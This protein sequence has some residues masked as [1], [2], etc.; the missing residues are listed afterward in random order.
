MS[1]ITSIDLAEA[2]TLLQ[3]RAYFHQYYFELLSALSFRGCFLY[4]PFNGDALGRALVEHRPHVRCPG[5]DAQE[6]EERCSPDVLKL[7]SGAKPNIFL[8][9]PW[10][11]VSLELVTYASPWNASHFTN[12]SHIFDYNKDVSGSATWCEKLKEFNNSIYPLD[13]RARLHALGSAQIA[14]YST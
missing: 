3:A 10:T 5:W 7:T 8:Q 4:P 11:T 6:G 12:K 2:A 14:P 1:R 9:Y 13:A